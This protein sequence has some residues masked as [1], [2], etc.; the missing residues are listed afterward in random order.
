MPP[1]DEIKRK[2]VRAKNK[3]ILTII[4]V[5]EPAIFEL[6]WISGNILQDA[7]MNNIAVIVIHHIFPHV[8]LISK[9]LVSTGS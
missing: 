3:Y 5:D 4:E 6:S 7:G 8:Y 1:I 2:K 9:N